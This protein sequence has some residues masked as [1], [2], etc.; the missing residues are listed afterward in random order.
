MA[1]SPAAGR[2]ERKLHMIKS[3]RMHEL[4]TRSFARQ[5]PAPSRASRRPG[6]GTGRHGGGQAAGGIA[7]TLRR[8]LRL[9][10]PPA[11][12]EDTRPFIRERRP[13][14]ATHAVRRGAAI[15]VAPE[16]TWLAQ[17]E[18]REIE[19]AEDERRRLFE[20]ARCAP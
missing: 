4:P 1:A 2:L 6:A 9:A 3:A 17:V 20:G 18:V 15:D 14:P 19:M 13:A 10:P 5:P 8:L 11:A 7:A 12:F 16:P